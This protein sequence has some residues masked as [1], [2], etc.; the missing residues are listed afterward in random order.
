MVLLD[1]MI[2]NVLKSLNGALYHKIKITP[3]PFWSE[4]GW[5]TFNLLEITL[6][7]VTI[8]AFSLNFSATVAATAL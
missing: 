4:T 1:V 2:I 5:L 8:Q 7:T 6:T 3:K